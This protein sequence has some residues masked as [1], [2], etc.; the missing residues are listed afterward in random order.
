L[1]G[2][3][4]LLLGPEEGEK[5]EWIDR[6][7]AELKRQYPDLEIVLIFAFESDGSDVAEA[8][9]GSS[10]FSSH[11]L[12]I[13]KHFEEAKK[14]SPLMK[15]IAE[16][17]KNPNEESHLFIVSSGTA[18]TIPAEITKAI[19]KENQI[20]FWELF[21]NKKK[22]WVRNYFSK[23]GLQINEEATELLLDLI[24]NNTAEMRS[25][26]SQLSLFFTLK[27]DKK[28]ITE[29]DISTY[30]AHTKEED[31]YTLFGHMAEGNLER[32]L[33]ALDRIFT[34]DPR[35]SIGVLAALQRQFRLL[36]SFLMLRKELGEEGA[37]AEA[38]ALPS[39]AVAYEVKGIKSKRDKTTF[40]N[41]A[42][43]FSLEDTDN[44]LSYLD[45]MDL[46]VRKASADQQKLTLEV[47]IYTILIGKGKETTLKLQRELMENSF[48]NI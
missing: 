43:R 12:V 5:Q 34:T 15:V 3:I 6:E 26:C 40:K 35:A 30:L 47:I 18:Y 7:K 9:G 46:E 25:Y 36:E 42:S 10:L 27:G 16:A 13:L 32:S 38:Q 44:I 8:L 21:E 33:G 37:F 22:E 39:G 24:E 2:N 29:E 19:P 45:R 48:S 23:Q 11:T 20:T 28:T 41:A 4:A 31:G 1:K 17:A 14:G